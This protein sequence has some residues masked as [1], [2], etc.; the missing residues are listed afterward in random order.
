MTLLNANSMTLS[1]VQN[2][3]KFRDTVERTC[4]Q[5]RN[6]LQDSMT[7]SNVRFEDSR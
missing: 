3:S 5:I 2:P 7:L 6:D 4:D 1:N